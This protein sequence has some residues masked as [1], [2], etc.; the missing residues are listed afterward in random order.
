MVLGHTATNTVA[1]KKLKQE[2]NNPSLLKKFNPEKQIVLSVDASK[3]GLGTI[4]L[5]DNS[6]V[7][8][9]SLLMTETQGKYTLI[10]KELSAVVF[11]CTKYHDF[12]YGNNAATETDH[13]T[14]ITIVKKPL[15]ASPA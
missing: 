14:I 9:A 13:K 11:A 15:H 1:L 4:C 10:Q 7:A 12:I 6:P 2:A 3:N 8:F 5:Q